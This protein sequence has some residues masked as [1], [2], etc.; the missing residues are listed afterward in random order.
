MS[1]RC[2]SDGG[3]SFHW[4][5]NHCEK[6]TT[7]T[8]TLHLPAVFFGITAMQLVMTPAAFSRGRDPSMWPT[9]HCDVNTLETT[10]A[11]AVADRMLPN[12][13]WL[14]VQGLYQVNAEAFTYPQD[15]IFYP[16][17][18]SWPWSAASHASATRHGVQTGAANTLGV[19]QF[20][21]PDAPDRA[22]R[23]G[24]ILEPRVI[25]L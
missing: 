4:R 18:G 2:A 12:A 1:K 23:F 9:S 7:S 14:T 17:P 3:A 6:R 8:I 20:G 15:K 5:Y 13:W 22:A 21:P 24:K 11:F 19:V 10:I 16:L 25:E